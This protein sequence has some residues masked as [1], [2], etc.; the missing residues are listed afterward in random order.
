MQLQSSDLFLSVPVLFFPISLH[1]S[2]IQYFSLPIL[3]NLNL[4]LLLFYTLALVGI[5]V[6]LS[7]TSICCCSPSEIGSLTEIW[8]RLPL[9]LVCSKQVSELSYRSPA[10]SESNYIGSFL[11]LNLPAQIMPTA[12]SSERNAAECMKL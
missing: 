4:F 9:P 5:L 10:R 8:F 7:I 6:S 3:Q 1:S 12:I 11:V 2:L